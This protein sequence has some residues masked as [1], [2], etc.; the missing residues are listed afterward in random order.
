M[1]DADRDAL[2]AALDE[3]TGVLFPHL[4]REEQQMMPVVATSITQREWH[5]WDQQY[6]IKPKKLPRL[7]EEGNWLIDGLDEPRRRIVEAEVPAIPRYIVLYGFGPGVS[8][9]R[10]TP[11]GN[12]RR[13]RPMSGIARTGHAEAV[14][15]AAPEEVWAVLADVTRVG[16]WSGECRRAVW[17]GSARAAVPGARFRGFN[18]SGWIRWRRDNEIVAA[19]APRELAWRTLPAL[20]FPDSTEWRFRLEPHGDGTRIVQS[21]RLLKIPRVI[22]WLFA[23]VIREHRDRDPGLSADLERLAKVASER[24]PAPQ[25]SPGAPRPGPA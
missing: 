5:R 8:P 10:G 15:A 20:R 13:G 18:R 16:E 9:A 21:Y 24:Q 17:T 14:S 6:N 4:E 19:D 22:D 2:V 23:R 7:A 11:L 12:R 25:P 3:L 1:T